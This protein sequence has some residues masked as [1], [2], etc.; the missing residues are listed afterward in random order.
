MVP[1]LTFGSGRMERRTHASF[2]DCQFVQRTNS[3][4]F[5]IM[6]PQVIIR[7]GGSNDFC[8]KI[9]FVEGK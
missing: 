9:G 3:L 2:A 5:E 7:V 1:P 6:A 8:R 4:D